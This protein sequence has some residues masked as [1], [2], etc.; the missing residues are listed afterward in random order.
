MVSVVGGKILVVTRNNLD[1]HD[2]GVARSVGLVDSSVFRW[3]KGVS[4]D[5][6]RRTT[7]T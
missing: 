7:R 3:S 2:V 5:A 4:S 1:V 6:V